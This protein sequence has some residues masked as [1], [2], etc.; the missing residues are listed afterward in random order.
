MEAVRFVVVGGIATVVHYAIYWLLQR[1][2]EVN[3]AYTAGYVLSFI[4]NFY[5]TAYFTFG[6]SPSWSRF[7]GMGGAHVVNYLLHMLLLNLFLYI[8]IPK[9]WAPLPVFGIAVPVNFLL[10]R[11]VFTHKKDR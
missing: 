4:L 11:F 5:L 2:I 6:K 9:T 7:L 1:V 3:V 10:V 8:G